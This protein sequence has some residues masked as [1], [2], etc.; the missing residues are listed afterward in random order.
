M[1]LTFFDAKPYDKKYFN[2]ANLKY[3]KAKTGICF[4]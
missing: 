4:L 1:K 2:Q 3:S